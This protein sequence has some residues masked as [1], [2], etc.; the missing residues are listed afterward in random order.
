M[1][2]STTRFECYNKIWPSGKIWAVLANIS[3][4]FSYHN[5]LTRFRCHNFFTFV[6]FTPTISRKMSK[7]N[8]E[9][10]MYTKNLFENC[11]TT[12]QQSPTHTVQNW[13]CVSYKKELMKKEST[14][15]SIVHSTSGKTS[16]VCT[17]PAQLESGCR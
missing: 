4:I 15:E 5:N 13:W 2:T 1:V 3:I 17:V 6:N 9:I 8:D 12:V 10:L 11:Q 16:T 14:Q 7:C